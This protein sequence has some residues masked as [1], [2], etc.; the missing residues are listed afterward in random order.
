MYPG[1]FVAPFGSCYII[2]WRTMS[3]CFCFKQAVPLVRFRLQV[4]SCFPW[5]VIPVSLQFPKSLLCFSGSVLPMCHQG[6]VWNGSGLHYTALDLPELCPH[7][8][9]QGPHLQIPP[10]FTPMLSSFQGPF[11]LEALTR[12]WGF[13]QSFYMPASLPPCSSVIRDYLWAKPQRKEKGDPPPPQ[14]PDNHILWTSRAPFLGSWF[15]KKRV[16]VL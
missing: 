14:R 13:S 6:H 11:L 1:Y 9:E 5:V 2:L 15:L 4:V 7:P 12:R 16:F 10:L 3:F 8:H